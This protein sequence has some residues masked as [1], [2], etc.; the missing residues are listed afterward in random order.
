M[1][2]TTIIFLLI[3][4]QHSKSCTLTETEVTEIKQSFSKAEEYMQKEALNEDAAIVI[5]P[6]RVGKSTL[7]NYLIGNKLRGV[8]FSQFGEFKII[9]AD[10]ESRGPEIGAGPTS[11]T[12]IPIKWKSAKLPGLSIFDC[13]GFQDNRGTVQDITNSIYIYQL[14]KKVKTL[15]FILVFNFADVERDNTASL[16][17]FL[18]DLEK[19]F[20]NK[21]TDFFPSMSIIFSKTPYRSFQNRVNIKMIKYKLKQKLFSTNVKLSSDAK[22]F[23]DYIIN[24]NN[25]IALFWKAKNDKNFSSD[26]D[27]QMFSAI[28]N[29]S[30][31]ERIFLDSIRPSISDSSLI[32]L[33]SS[34]DKFVSINEIWEIEESLLLIFTE[35]LST[36]SYDAYYSNKN[37]MMVHIRNHFTEIK[38]LLDDSII[39][40]SDIYKNIEIIKKIDK[41]LEEKINDSN[42]LKKVEM[43]NF[44][45]YLLQLEES[46]ILHQS[47]EATML[48][49]QALLNAKISRNPWLIGNVT[50]DEQVNNNGEEQETGFI[51]NLWNKVKKEILSSML[52]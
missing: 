51:F 44:I 21:F 49:L 3:S 8:R 2:R 35:K 46:K 20:G 7:I 32:C 11:K 41:Q 14:V 6:G 13:P 17:R 39:N 16:S 42:L 27:F 36:W 40:G 38:V 47:V 48:T 4:L 34:K 28:T 15:K 26:T 23:V 10:N 31:I 12:T 33:Q 52:F 18:L 37:T 45:S 9:K 19:F 22:K 29:S 50:E 1:L 30:S 43:Y 24:N 25:S 5:G